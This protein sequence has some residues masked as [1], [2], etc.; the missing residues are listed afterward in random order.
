MTTR[1]NWE[2]WWT[3]SLQANTLQ[4]WDEV[5]PDV[6]K[7]V[8]LK[9]IHVT[10]P[11]IATPQRNVSF[12]HHDKGDNQQKTELLHYTILKTQK[13][14]SASTPLVGYELLF[15]GCSASSWQYLQDIH[16]LL[17]LNLKK[18]INKFLSTLKRTTEP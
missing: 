3:N 11:L 13:V 15:E 18:L 8:T 7:T 6:E 5:Y 12:H 16:F 17:Q 9:R 1:Q 2:T 10:T 4:I 14:V